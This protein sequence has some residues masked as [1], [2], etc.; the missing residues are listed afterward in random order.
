MRKTEYEILS[1]FK[2]KPNNEFSTSDIVMNVFPSKSIELDDIIKSKISSQEQ[3]KLAKNSKAKLHRRVL[4]YLNK[5][6]GEG[7]VELKREGSKGE[8]F[9][10]L[11]IND[12]E[13]YIID[14]YKRRIVIEKPI[15]PAVPIEGYEQKSFV[16]RQNPET[17]VERLNAILLESERFDNLKDYYKKIIDCF[18]DVNDVVSLNDFESLFINNTSGSVKRFLSKLDKMCEDY[19]KTIS[20]IIDMTNID[21][22]FDIYNLLRSKFENINFIFDLRVGELRDNRQFI[23]KAVE[24]V[25]KSNSILYFKNQDLH[26]APY[27]IGAAGPYTFNPDEWVNYIKDVRK[28][29]QGIACAQTSVTIDVYRFW[30]ENKSASQFRSMLMAVVKA[31]LT[32]NSMQRRKS[33]EYFNVSTKLSSQFLSLS[34]SYIRFW[35]YGWRQ[36]GIDPEDTM[37]LIKKLDQEVQNFSSSQETIYLSCGIPTRFKVCFSCDFGVQ[38]PQ[39]SKPR[40]GKLKISN[41]EALHSEETKKMLSDKEKLF[42]LFL[43]G[44]RIRFIRLGS[45]R[46]DDVWR[47]I[48]TI[49]TSYKIPFF[50]YDFS[51]SHKNIKLTEFV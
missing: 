39:L 19:G 24:A 38:N 29:S 44:D 26:A 10:E 8:K 41:S 46:A 3:L 43:G 5:L 9:F 28:D 18:S 40:F 27:M 20:C 17:W 25:S 49:F 1:F 51:K 37:S 16:H 14:K 35:N 12:D 45:P 42:E 48:N 31:L 22:K 21:Q 7:I 33:A 50:C 36:T 11:G 47:E 30:T 6:I 2:K 32:A 15:M 23:E 13:R 34:R 4:Y